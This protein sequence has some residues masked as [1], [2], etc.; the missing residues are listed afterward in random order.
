MHNN[1]YSPLLLLPNTFRAFYGAFQ[2][3]HPI[4]E[5]AIRPVLESRD[6]IVQSATGSGKT[7]AVLAPCLERII[8]SGLTFDIR[9]RFESVLV[10][11]LGLRFSIRT[12]DIKRTGGG[13][14]DIMLT[15]P[16]SLD[17]MLGSSNSDLRGF[18]SRVR[19]VIIDEVHPYIHQYRGRQLVYVLQRLERRIGEQ[20]QKIALSATIADPDAVIR[21]LGFRPDTVLLT[22]N[23]SRQIFPRL[24]H[25]KDDECELVTLLDDLYRE[26]GYRKI[27]IFANS[28]GRCDKIF[29]LLNRQGQFMGMA[30]LHYSNLNARE[31][32]IVEKRNR[33]EKVSS[34]GPV[35]LYC[36][37]HPGAGY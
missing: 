15:T 16:E 20:L 35:G 22:E 19:T 18:V 36:N 11:R 9:R 24:I 13:F 21:F 1:H 30:E 32:Q 25:L 28:R 34:T 12:G 37:Q 8:R 17:V 26:W 33:R 3:L 31:R 23:V 7:E 4:Q 14:P 6:L 27:L 2:S 29:G 10:E 5:R